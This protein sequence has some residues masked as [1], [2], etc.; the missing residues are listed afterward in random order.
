MRAKVVLFAAEGMGNQVIWQRLDLPR[1]D[2][3][4]TNPRDPP[5]R[6]ADGERAHRPLRLKTHI[7]MVLPSDLNSL[8]RLFLSES[9]QQI[10]RRLLSS[11]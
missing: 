11:V 3:N 8:G 9:T 6:A 2:P 10:V 5:P 7:L 1:Q 4:P